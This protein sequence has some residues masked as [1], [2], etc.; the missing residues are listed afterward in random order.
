[1]DEENKE[2]NEEDINQEEKEQ[3][4]QEETEQE[5]QNQEET[6][7]P[8][9]GSNGANSSSPSARER[10]KRT[11]EQIN[12]RSRAEVQKKIKKE[13]QKKIKKETEK[14][15]AKEAAKK[16]A[17]EA[18]KKE[19]AKAAAKAA[20]AEAAKAAAAT[21]AKAT[22][23]TAAAATAGTGGGCAIGCAV[24]IVI[25][26]IIILIIGSNSFFSNMPDSIIGKITEWWDDTWRET[27]V[28]WAESVSEE[29]AKERLESTA[30][31]VE[32]M[33]YDLAGYGFLDPGEVEED[34]GKK[35]DYKYIEVD[36][37]E[38]GV[39]YYGGTN[40][41]KDYENDVN[42]AWT[43]SKGN[44]EK[45]LPGVDV[46]DNMSVYNSTNT[47]D[48][49]KEIIQG[50]FG[51]DQPSYAVIRVRIVEDEDGNKKIEPGKDD[52][53]SLRTVLEKEE[54]GDIRLADSRVL[55]SYIAAEERTYMFKGQWWNIHDWW[56]GSFWDKLDIFN[57]VKD[58]EEDREG[59][60]EFEESI[61][62]E[63][64]EYQ[65][66]H[67]LLH[68]V[69]E[70]NERD[71]LTPWIDRANRILSISYLGET[72]TGGP[73]KFGEYNYDLVGWT[74][75]YGKPIEF[76]LAMHLATMSPDFTYKFATDDELESVVSIKF[77]K[78]PSSR[79]LLK[80]GVDAQKAEGQRLLE[81]LEARISEI[82]SYEN[83]VNSN[84]NKINNL[85]S[86]LD[87]TTDAQERAN[88]QAEIDALTSDE[89]KEKQAMLDVLNSDEV[90]SDIEKLKE[91]FSADIVNESGRNE[92]KNIVIN[93][94]HEWVSTFSVFGFSVFGYYVTGLN[95]LL[96]MELDIN[97]FIRICQ[98]NEHYNSVP[99]NV[100]Y[101]SE[102]TNHWYRNLYFGTVNNGP[103]YVVK[104]D[105]SGAATEITDRDALIQIL[106]SYSDD[107]AANRMEKYV[108][109]ILEIQEEYKVNALFTAAVGII[110]SRWGTASN[111]NL[112]SRNN[113]FSISGT[114]GNYWTRPSD[115]QKF[116]AYSSPEEGI[117]AFGRLIGDVGAGGASDNYYFGKGN[118]TVGAIAEHYCN[119]S[120]GEDVNKQMQVFYQYAE[121]NN[122][123][124]ETTTTDDSDTM[125][126]AD[127]TD[128]AEDTD[129]NFSAY[130]LDYSLAETYE[131]SVVVNTFEIESTAPFGL[132]TV[133]TSELVGTDLSADDYTVQVTIPY[134]IK[135][136]SE[137]KVYDNSKRIKEL[138][139]VADYDLKELYNEELQELVEQELEENGVELEDD[140][141]WLRLSDT[142]KERAKYYTFNGSGRSEEKQ[143]ISPTKSSISAMAILENVH[144]EDAAHILKD[145]KELFNDIGFEVELEEDISSTEKNQSLKWIFKDYVPGYDW[146]LKDEIPVLEDDR[147]TYSSRPFAY[148]VKNGNQSE[149][150]RNGFTGG[151]E[152]VTPGNCIVKDVGQDYIVLEFVDVTKTE[153]KQV[154]EFKNGKYELVEVEETMYDNEV[155]G[156][157]LY[158]YGLD[159]EE[160]IEKD[161]KLEAETKIG[162]ANAEKNL[163]MVMKDQLNSP[164]VVSQYIYPP[165]MTEVIFDLSGLEGLA[166]E[167]WTKYSAEI[168]EMAIKYGLDPYAII[169]V[170]CVESSGRLDLDDNGI[171]YGLMQ[172]HM[173]YHAVKDKVLVDVDGNKETKDCSPSAMKGNASLQI[174]C[175]CHVLRSYIFY[176][177]WTG[178]NWFRGLGAY[179][180]GPSG[181]KKPGALDRF[182]NGYWG[183]KYGFV[184]FF[185]GG[186]ETWAIKKEGGKYYQIFTNIE[187][188]EI[189][190]EVE[191]SWPPAGGLKVTIGGGNQ[192]AANGDG[193]T[194]TYTSTAGRTFNEFK[195]SR[196]SYKGQLYSEGTISSSGC[197]PTSVAIVLSGYGQNVDPGDIAKAMGGA[198][199]GGT[200][201]SNL[202]SALRKYGLGARQVSRP[203]ASQIRTQ[204]QSGK[205]IV[206]SVGSSPD[207]KFTGS[208]HIMAILDI[209]SNDEVYISNPNPRTYNGWIPLNQFIKYCS[210]KYAVFVE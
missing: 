97:E 170:I 35:V 80:N 83:E 24:A 33:G 19:A 94:K 29:L 77:A 198:H 196:G 128:D 13:M 71:R 6:Q 148:V 99:I 210:Y 199:N 44:L 8:S 209:N 138:L 205:E 59:M 84:Q 121:E 96:K 52:K 27:K 76:S 10:I 176:D 12:K 151:E 202:A 186:E 51:A 142:Y 65:E 133:E 34:E 109:T 68:I 177:D 178:G 129:E 207:S 78:V 2:L 130:E 164:V 106:K 131:T 25:I 179:N 122:L 140:E 40:L 57:F 5:E 171:A 22:A 49:I 61:L 187:T 98:Y 162:T 86:R 146:P 197:G 132:P 66:E 192:N 75:K 64:E 69:D 201:G 37:D 72:I 28:Y 42:R 155:N 168:T 60:I 88:I 32:N 9:S 195:Q 175:G 63:Y 43:I 137:P 173:K 54:N 48:I 203:S 154:R 135:Q 161:Q 103:G 180:K 115:G 39:L 74:G 127:T 144:T 118:I 14:R 126:D 38:Y 18:A 100:P 136:V 134:G 139:G 56:E 16:A 145:F 67:G 7:K 17:V 81:Q 15:I 113:W 21:T 125:D 158:V 70:N 123:L 107:E 200:N 152:L 124:P 191:V 45:I 30:Q 110:E 114:Q 50:L 167:V 36:V 120:W 147:S 153:K 87:A 11:Q 190:R 165:E 53:G 101:I 172:C 159:V 166:L 105:A 82:E 93:K 156:M 149:E 188:G 116:N 91:C 185:Y 119:T 143:N 90:K 79:R 95:G 160:G 92:I 46:E 174:E 184:N 204:L 3:S 1:M 108:D 58:V 20:A 163:E 102:V 194:T 182:R 117:R 4:E 47:S 73:I 193:Y 41:S 183:K 85:E 169:A 26:V 89:F 157:V 62:D 31:Y 55:L 112:N 104:T 208:G 23:T 206:V 189:T 150:D 141:A 111:E 181:I